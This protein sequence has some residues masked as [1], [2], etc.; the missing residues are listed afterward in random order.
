[1]TKFSSFVIFLSAAMQV[2]AATPSDT[3]K[4]ETWVANGTVFAIAPSGNQ[5]YI[6]GNFTSLGPDTGGGVPI[7]ASTGVPMPGIPKVNGNVRAA[8]ADGKGGWFIS[9]LFTSVGNAA[10][11]YMAHILSNGTVDPHWNPNAN[12]FALSLAVSGTTVFAGGYFDTIGGQGRKGI[13]ALDAT[14]G[15]VLPW[16][17]NATTFFFPFIRVG[18]LAIRGTTVYAGGNFVII[19]GLFRNHI[20]ALDATTGEALPWNPNANGEVYSISVSGATVYVAGVFDSIGGQRRI[21]LASVDATTGNA[22][23]W[24]PNPDSLVHSLAVSGT[25]VYAGGLFTGIGGTSRNRIAAFDAITGNTLAWNPNADG[26]VLSLAVSGTT[27]YAGG[28]FTSIGQGAGRSYFAQ[29]GEYVP[30]PVARPVPQFF[31]ANSSSLHITNMSGSHFHA[32][33]IVKFAYTLPRAGHVSLRLYSVTGQIQSELINKY[34]AAG[35]YTLQLQRG[36]LAAGAYLAVF[37]AGDYHQE[38]MVFL[39]K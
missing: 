13:A 10:C 36:P 16:N 4:Q 11:K 39:T 37:R 18:S 38:K 7:D 6:G 21:F 3:C 35:N 8:C 9:G 29:F 23:A 25:T 31:N 26:D 24:N 17:P 5:I 33:A 19:G 14:T 34:Q 12:N 30:N 32:G 15:N 22:T 27:V 20:A 28:S 2:L 1:M